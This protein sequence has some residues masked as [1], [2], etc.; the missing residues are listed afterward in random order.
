MPAD[1]LCYTANKDDLVAEGFAEC[2]L[3]VQAA[4]PAQAITYVKVVA[5]DAATVGAAVAT[6]ISPETSISNE[7]LL[8]EY[9][10]QDE[11]DRA[12]F[13]FTDATTGTSHDL[14]FSLKYYNPAVGSDNYADSDNCPSGAYIFKPKEG[15]S[16]KKAYSTFLKMETYKAEA[17]GV[18]AFAVYY[19]SEDNEKLYTAL[20]RVMPGAKALEWEVQL[21]GIPIG[22]ALNREGKEVVVN[23]EMLSFDNADTFYTDS[24]GLEMQ[25]R[26]LNYR[27]DWN[28]TTDEVA[29]SNYYPIN[30]AV[31]LRDL[32]T[33]MQLTIMNDRSQGGSVGANGSVEILQNRRLLKDDW[34]GVGEALNE[35]NA[36][37]YGIQ[38]NTR[39]FLQL[40]DFTA[41]PSLQRQIQLVVDEPVTYFVTGV[42][43]AE[44]AELSE[45]TTTLTEPLVAAFDG[46]LKIHLIPE[47][48]N[49]ILVRLENLAD[50]FDGAPSTTPMFDVAT[51]AKNLFV[52]NNK[53]DVGAFTTAIS[54]RTLSNNQD[55]AEMAAGR[56]QWPTES[57]P[58]P[59][60]YP[61]DE[62]ENAVVALQPQRIR[63][64]RVKYEL[65]AATDVFLQ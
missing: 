24:N 61:A 27:P 2:E 58:S 37:G 36:S 18:Q 20:I 52:A 31:A 32:N 44:A 28:L 51:Y 38:V 57:G 59:T 54:E 9:V 15:D 60:V 5:V 1:V 65:A 45:P 55:Y 50:L 47:G 41:S 14:A 10:A 6:A 23:W 49:Q 53:A 11:L 7:S 43:S 34:R 17:T 39:Y 35:K 64:F 62:A 48:K 22:S 19:A 13:K 56:F 40:F 42:Y 46:D 8:L 63:L 29:S 26:V 3:F 33:N 30:S 25:K 4:V 16:D 21:H 12:L